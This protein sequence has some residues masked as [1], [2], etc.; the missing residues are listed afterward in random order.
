MLGLTWVAGLARREK[1]RTLAAVISVAAAVALL[2]S[3]GSFV[4]GAKSTMTKR[5][6][7]Q[8]PVDWQV[9]A[10]PG[11]DQTTLL[12]AV[13]HDPRVRTAVA[14]G[15]A[16]TAGFQATTAGTTQTTGPGVALGLPPG[17]ATTFPG[18]L[19]LL[20]GRVDGALVAQ[21]TAANLHVAPGDAIEVQRA[22]LGPVTVTVDGVVD[23]PEANSLFQKVG[24]PAGAQP[25]APPDNVVL[26][27]QA[28]WQATFGPLGTSRPDLVR[29]QVHARLRHA[30]PADPAAAFTRVTGWS[31]N[32][33]ARLAGAG[34]VGDNLGAALDAARADAL[35]AQVLF[36]FLGVPGAVLAAL[37]T[38]AV[39]S[40]AADRR[41]HHLGLL[42]TRGATTARMVRLAGAEAAVVGTLGAAAGLGVAATVGWRTFGSPAFG[43]TTGEA[44][45]WAVGAALIGLAIAVSAVLLPVV[46]DARTL[47][48]ESARRRAPTE[49]RPVWARLALDVWLLG[50]AAVVFWLTS[51]KSYA[52]VLAPEGVPTVSVSYWALLG[53]ALAWLASGLFIWRLCETLLRR[54]GRIVS[55]A[56]RPLSPRLG[57]TVAATL[58][59]RRRRLAWTT[60]VIGLSG[61][62]AISTAV[63]NSTYRQQVGVDARLT[64]G[65]DVSVTA[66]AAAAIPPSTVA[67][68]SALPGVKHAE[69][70][71]HG[72]AYVG[73]DLQDIYGVRPK[74]VV[75]ATSLQDA[76]FGGGTAAGLMRR[77]GGQPD[78]VLVS[79]ETVHDFQLNPGDLLRLRIRDAKTG[80][81]TEVPFHYVGVVKEFPTAPRDSFLV[82]NA[83][84]LAAHVGGPSPQTLLLDV[85]SSSPRAVAARVRSVVG[86]SASVS[87]IVS[88]RRV[89]A[90]SLTAVDLAGLTRVELGFGLALAVAACG[91]LVGLDLS[92][93]KRSFAITRAL[94]ARDRQV[95]AFVRSEVGVVVLVGA[96]AAVAVGWGVAA[97]LVKVLT[98][99]FDP[100][101]AHLAVPAAYL[102][103]LAVF[104]VVAAVAASEG[105][106]RAARRPIIEMVRDL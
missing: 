15:V 54:G 47:T 46:R 85:G 98:G 81:L 45:A 68:L 20:A 21:Q 70:L 95:A 16:Q 12:D 71:Q 30:L 32:L 103:L 24:A 9:E 1:G 93:R 18:E 13:R 39:A 52:L 82:A 97:M 19:R 102:G 11:A 2:A 67:R 63:F 80:A 49:Q 41:R 5:A 22:G 25:Q 31:R 75:G 96:L 86:T 57:D 91:V 50:A 44:A 42:R 8:V 33:E 105:A 87:D 23:L 10:Q 26:M 84:Y 60:A 7:A 14:V 83:S 59:R 53:P 76:Y 69:P 35:Y 51:R 90:S 29:A 48:P 36:L 79:A 65:A 3:I 62:F 43:A 56:A 100:P 101:P 55:L 17:Y 88:G 99:V 73:A 34:L 92:E 72:F 89:A 66:P 4:A 58:R 37:L 64:N 61:A 104:A 106:V 28:A 6:V 38:T 78:G 94:G 27:P 74:T 40:S 77:L